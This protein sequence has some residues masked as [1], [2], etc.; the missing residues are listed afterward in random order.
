MC[1]KESRTLSLSLSHTH[2]H[3][4]I[5]AYTHTYIH[6]MD[7]RMCHKESRTLSLSLIHTHTH[8]HTHTY[9]HTH[10]HSYIPWIHECVIKRLECGKSHKYLNIQIY[11]AKH[12][13]HLTKIRSIIFV[14]GTVSRE[15]FKTL[16]LR[17]LC[18]AAH[19]IRL[20]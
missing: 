17:K 2:T 11:S 6:S 19:V 20:V 14:R 15:E 9:I 5:H 3:T 12:Y 10:I 8:T 4:H 16:T 1:H 13:E 7:P 18:S